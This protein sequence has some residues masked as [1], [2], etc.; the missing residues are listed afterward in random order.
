MLRKQ[1]FSPEKYD[2]NIMAALPY[3]EE[4]FKQIIEIVHTA[5]HIP[6]A[7]LD[8]GCGTGKMADMAIRNLQV[9]N[10]VCCDNSPQM[11]KI[12]KERVCSLKV[13]FR[14]V[15]IQNLQYN[16]DFDIITAILIIHYLEYEERIASIRNC[17]NALKKNG[18]FFTVENFAPN[19][20]CLKDYIWNGGKSISTKM[21]KAKKNVK[22]IYLDIIQNTFQS[23]LWSKF[24]YCRNVDL[25]M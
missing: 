7:W 17:Y 3:Y 1:A 16:S 13:D 15:L 10:M 19:N 21:G 24:M 4:Y 22:A 12:A 9:E 18:L 11:L 14:K 2:K 23:P 6:I 8:I 20:E 25:K 5:F